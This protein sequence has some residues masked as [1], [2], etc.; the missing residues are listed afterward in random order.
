ME[1]AVAV[2]VAEKKLFAKVLIGDTYPN[3]SN[4]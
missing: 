1:V 2:A 3:N 4:N